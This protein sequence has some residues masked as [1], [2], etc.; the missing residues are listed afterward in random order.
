MNNIFQV[1][2][3][4]WLDF[5]LQMTCYIIWSY[6]SMKWSFI[7][8]NVQQFSLALNHSLKIFYCHSK[9]CHY[10]QDTCPADDSHG[11]G[12]HQYSQQPTGLSLESLEKT[13][14]TKKTIWMDRSSSKKLHIQYFVICVSLTIFLQDDS[15]SSRAPT[16]L[17]KSPTMFSAESL[18]DGVSWGVNLPPVV[19]DFADD[20]GL[21]CCQ[22]SRESTSSASLF[23]SEI[24]RVYFTYRF[25]FTTK[26]IL[27]L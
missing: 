20:G 1:L 24:N 16:F 2:R 18:A 11:Q 6:W 21:S 26:T 17:N 25:S 22:D 9:G 15:F 10:G 8:T 13:L 3:F 5:F 12:S 27:K 7:I 14:N 23:E 19:D 4:F